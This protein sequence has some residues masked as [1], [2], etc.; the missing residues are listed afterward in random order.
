LEG[1]ISGLSLFLIL[2]RTSSL[3]FLFVFIRA[4]LASRGDGVASRGGVLDST[5]AQGVDKLWIS[6]LAR[7]AVVE[8]VLA[9][10]V[11]AVAEDDSYVFRGQYRHG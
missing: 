9:R 8:A 6:V 3:Y 5:A 1:L 11:A 10:A 2:L 4:V 7:A